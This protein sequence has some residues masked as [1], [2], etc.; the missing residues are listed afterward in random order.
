MS[1]R[2]ATR[3]RLG[4]EALVAAQDRFADRAHAARRTA[5][6][7][8]GAAV[9][10][11]LVAALAAWVVL[12]SPLLAVRS[13]RVT[14]V[15]AGERAGVRALADVPVGTPLARVDTGAVEDR[16][17][18]RP[19]IAHVSVRRE[20]PRTVVVDATARTP[21]LAVRD[22]AGALTVLD[23]EGVAFETVDTAPTGVPVIRADT[24]GSV[25]G[26]GVRTALAVLSTLPPHIAER[27][28]DLTVSDA[29]V[30][31]FGVGG[32]DVVWGTGER[33]ELKGEVVAALLRRHPGTID[34]SAPET[35]VTR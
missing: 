8:A 23:I 18:A 31:T 4:A 25:S 20:W 29:D 28:R 17:A 6:V 15:P 21:V 32:T 14:G 19:A 12:A 16:V 33:P 11:V 2:P 3:R 27:V 5:R 7:R 22:S 35:P 24:S 30:V 26:A 10:A 1:S 13:V 9:A 34:V